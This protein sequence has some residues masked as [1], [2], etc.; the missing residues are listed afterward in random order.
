MMVARSASPMM[1]V[2]MAQM[3]T[4]ILPS[5]VV[6]LAKEGYRYQLVFTEFT[7]GMGLPRL[8]TP[9]VVFMIL[10]VATSPTCFE[11]VTLWR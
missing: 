4:L 11:F 2:L 3:Y 1:T 8:S 7:V 6:S 9:W 10:R 5:I